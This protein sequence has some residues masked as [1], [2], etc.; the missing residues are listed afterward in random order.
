MKKLFVQGAGISCAL[1]SAIAWSNPGMQAPAQ[2]VSASAF[3]IAINPSINLQSGQPFKNPTEV[4]STSNS[5]PLNLTIGYTQVNYNGGTVIL[6][7]Y[8]GQ[9]V[10]PTVHVKPQ[11]TLFV[12]L[13]NKLATKDQ[14]AVSNLHTHG[15]H[16]SPDGNQDNIFLTVPA[17][18]KQAYAIQVPSD[19]RRGTQWYHPHVHGNTSF[20]V[21]QGMEGALIVDDDPAQLP[22]SLKVK[23][24]V[25]VVQ[26]LPIQATTDTVDE[27]IDVPKIR[28]EASGKGKSVTLINGQVVPKITMNQGEVQRWRLVNATP[29]RTLN[30]KLGGL[31]L[32]EIAVDGMYLGTVDTWPAGKALTLQPGNRSDVLVKA[33]DDCSNNKCPTVNLTNGDKET[34]ATVEFVASGK[35]MPLPTSAEMQ[36]LKTWKNIDTSAV[37]LSE[38]AQFQEE[39]CNEA[40]TMCINGITFNADQTTKLPLNKTQL[41]NL[42][43]IDNDHVFHIHV[44]PFQ[45]TRTGPNGAQ[46]IV[47]MDTMLVPQ[48]SSKDNPVKAWT[49]YENI[50]G[51]AVFHCHILPHEDLGM[52]HAIQIE[53]AV[54]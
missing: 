24:N 2:A 17:N 33:P 23:E 30:L 45:T 44:N 36:A 42:W 37:T 54:Q 20:Q 32:N 18:S 16:V 5:N 8:N 15:L 10:G 41:W 3:K 40:N 22:P 47:W 46:E 27:K 21:S 29:F 48:G 26:Y 13:D 49:T 43:T 14:Y 9:L 53:K 12:N 38:P 35:P 31:A 4:P 25:M 6:R 39:G 28:S 50:P 34:I 11:A 51:K 1:V 19:Q 7:T 52:M